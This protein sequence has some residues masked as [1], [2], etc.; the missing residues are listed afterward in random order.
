MATTSPASLSVFHFCRRA[1]SH[2]YYKT[3]KKGSKSLFLKKNCLRSGKNCKELS[4]Y[5]EKLKQTL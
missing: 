1:F 3:A 2:Y 5:S 4:L